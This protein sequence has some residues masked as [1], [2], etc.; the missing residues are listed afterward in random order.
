MELASM[1]AH[2]PFSDHP[3]AVCPVIGE[4]LRTYNDVVDDE[5]RQDLYAYAAAVVGTRGTKADEQRRAE[6]CL[7]AAGRARRWRATTMLW[8]AQAG[9][10]AAARL[11][12][13]RN[14]HRQALELLD[15]LIARGA[16]SEAPPAA[17]PAGPRP[18]DPLERLAWD[19]R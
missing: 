8:R 15:R 13:R 12:R 7:D 10:R 11:A 14:R 5:R 1:L 9:Y 3:S 6:L 4:F 16:E 2:E 18:A 17:L 19:L